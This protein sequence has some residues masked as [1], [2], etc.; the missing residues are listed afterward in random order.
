M[1]GQFVI[2][3]TES[4][5][6][7][8]VGQSRGRCFFLWDTSYE[9]A[10]KFATPSLAFQWAREHNLNCGFRVTGYAKVII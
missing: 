8:L 9:L 3:A 6:T 5:D 7:Y 4:S 10:L 1:I 2:E